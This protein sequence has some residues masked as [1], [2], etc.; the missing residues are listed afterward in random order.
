MVRGEPLH[1]AERASE[2]DACRKRRRE[3]AEDEKEAGWERSGG[4]SPEA[5][6]EGESVW[7]ALSRH[8]TAILSKQVGGPDAITRRQIK[9]C[10]PPSDKPHGSQSRPDSG[11]GVQV[12][13]L[14]TF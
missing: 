5:P 7:E 2:K 11:L 8:V 10:P 6:L 3:R 14:E 12:N 1:E 9:V 4:D 13:V